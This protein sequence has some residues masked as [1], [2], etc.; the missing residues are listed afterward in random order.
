MPGAGEEPAGVLRRAIAVPFCQLA[1]DWGRQA[2]ELVAFAILAG[3][4]LEEAHHGLGFGGITG[5]NHCGRN[6]LGEVVVW[7]GRGFVGGN[8]Q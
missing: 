2:Q 5:G 3:A 8:G 1:H 6:G 4:G 7:H